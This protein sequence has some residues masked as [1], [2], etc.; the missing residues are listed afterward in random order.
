MSSIFL[1]CSKECNGQI[2]HVESKKTGSKK[3]SLY[4][5]TGFFPKNGFII[6]SDVDRLEGKVLKDV[7]LTEALDNF[8]QS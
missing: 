6:I 4:L 8:N 5:E 2:A 1:E 3:V 7:Q